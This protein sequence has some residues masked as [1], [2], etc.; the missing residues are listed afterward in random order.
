MAKRDLVEVMRIAMRLDPLDAPSQTCK[1]ACA[2]GA[3]AP[4]LW[5]F[6]LY[7]FFLVNPRLAQLFMVCSNIKL[8]GPAES[9]GIVT[10]TI[11]ERNQWDSG[12][13]VQRKLEI[14]ADANLA[15]SIPEEGAAVHCSPPI[16]RRIL[17][18]ANTPCRTCSRVRV[19]LAADQVD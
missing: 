14:P 1:R 13:D 15:R 4:L 2:C 18:S 3:H 9:I 16:P 11:R 5:E 7:R 6:G 17:A 10:R 8:T 19:T 12:I